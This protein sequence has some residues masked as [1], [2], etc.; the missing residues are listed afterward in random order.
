VVEFLIT[1]EDGIY[2]D[3]TVGDGGHTLAILEKFKSSK[4]IGIDIDKKALEKARERLEFF[5]N[6][7]KLVYGD[8]SDME[9]IIRED[10]E[11][12]Y[13]DGILFDLGIRLE[14]VTDKFRGFSFQKDGPLDMRFDR[15]ATKTA[16][17]V[18]NNYSEEMLKKIFRNN[19][20]IKSAGKIA[21]KIVNYRQ[22]KPIET[23]TQLA[24]ICAG[25]IPSRKRTD[26]LAR[27]FQA[28]RIEVNDEFQ[29]LRDALKNSIEILKSSGRIVI[30]SYHSGED[31]IV[32]NYF[33]TESKDCIC[34]PGLPVC[35]CGHKRSIRI[36]TKKAVRPDDEEIAQ[37]PKAR[38]AKLRA[39]EKL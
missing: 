20:D 14:M 7:L 1:N 2:V 5:G 9:R 35:R 6:R 15:K 25:D 38:S 31:R 16:Y 28:I 17:R 13:V 32:K 39:V 19:S 18:V 10:C 30:I 29:K 23:T 34:P 21:R 11:I 33:A 3:A 36:L 24:E 26:F 27:V 4:V 37:N 8:Y 12:D 22:M